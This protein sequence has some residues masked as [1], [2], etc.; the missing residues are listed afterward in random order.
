[1]TRFEHAHFVKTDVEGDVVYGW[2]IVCTQGG[3][4][5][6]DLQGDVI[7]E[8]Q[9]QKA[10]TR[11]MLDRRGAKIMHEGSVVGDVV[12]SV[13]MTARMV[14]KMGLVADGTP[15]LKT[16]WFVGVKFKDSA[17]LKRFADGD[18]TGFSI[19]GRGKRF[20]SRAEMERAA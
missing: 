19:G 13:P 10:A 15:V 11:F 16:G 8:D 9:M 5:Y 4:E 17:I 18:L 2:A 7:T 1:M 3:E 6:V 20:D 12:C 14:A